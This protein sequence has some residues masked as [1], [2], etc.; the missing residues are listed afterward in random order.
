MGGINV[1]HLFKK[2]T[3][4]KMDGSIWEMSDEADGGAIIKGGRVVNQ[5]KINELA[6]IEM[7]KQSA[8]TAMA[9]Q[10]ES[11][12]VDARNGVKDA[13][14]DN[15]PAPEVVEP[16]KVEAKIDSTVPLVDTNLEQRVDAMEGKLDQI[17]DA[18]KK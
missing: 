14:V 3:V 15:T 9:N 1:G 4:R 11:P 7:D 10:V 17:L 13:V 5:E 2:R 18:L 8:G 16:P 12:N 6:K